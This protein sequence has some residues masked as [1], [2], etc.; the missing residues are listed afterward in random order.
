MDYV[1]QKAPIADDQAGVEAKPPRSATLWRPT[2]MRASWCGLALL[3]L[4]FAPFA[5]ASGITWDER[6]HH[7]YG[8]A[9][10]Q[11]YSSGFTDRSA[12]KHRSHLYG[13]LFDLAGDWLV[14]SRLLP[15]GPY[16]TQHVLAAFVALLGV[17][18]CWKTAAKIAG[19]RAG[20]LAAAL[21]VLTPCW[22]GHGMF[23]PKDI[24]FGSAVAFVAYAT[25]CIASHPGPL[26]W[27]D[28]L[29]TGFAVGAALGVRSGGMFLMLFPCAA[30]GLRLALDTLCAKREGNPLHLGRT[31]G[32]AVAGFSVAGVIAWALML[33]A[34]PWGQVAPFAR[35]L[36]AAKTAAS[37]PHNHPVL[38]DGQFV[39]STQL[40][41]DYLFTWFAIT[42]PELYA[43]AALF[44]IAVCVIKLR[45]RQLSAERV[46]PLAMLGALVALPLLGVLI[47]HP[48]LYDGQRHF[49]FLLPPTAALLGVG[50]DGFLR[51]LA[52]LRWRIAA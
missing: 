16:E 19:P 14:S 44:A 52:A 40:P 41:R 21:L 18:A 8:R 3:A 25:V 30:A 29:R 42:L 28:A 39:M 48:V 2:W 51:E 7:S 35:P 43:I 33:S 5:L 20:F 38:F 17:I 34:W 27:S 49:L 46:L 24:P 50:V 22:V 4:G 23:N 45:A 37:F 15:F 1:Q 12:L 9:I 13:G 47:K 6:L 10:A 11:W 26:R 32:Q 31:L 36:K